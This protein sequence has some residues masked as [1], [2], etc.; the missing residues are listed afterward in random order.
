MVHWCSQ[1]KLV[2]LAYLFFI[3]SI[4]SCDTAGDTDSIPIQSVTTFESSMPISP[5][6]C[7]LPMS[8][9]PKDLQSERFE[10]LN[11][12]ADDSVNG[13]S[14]WSGGSSWRNK[15]ANTMN[16]CRSP[17]PGPQT[18]HLYW[19]TVFANNIAVNVWPIVTDTGQVIV[20][21]ERNIVFC[22]NADGSLV[23]EHFSDNEIIDIQVGP[24]S[25]VFIV[26]DNTFTVLNDIGL[27]LWEMN[28][29]N[30]NENYGLRNSI[31]QGLI[32]L[33]GPVIAL[34]YRKPAGC[35][36]SVYGIH[37]FTLDGDFL[38]SLGTTHIANPAFHSDNYIVYSSFGHLLAMTPEGINVWG[39]NDHIYETPLTQSTGTTYTS[40]NIGSWGAPVHVIEATDGGGNPLFY[41]MGFT[42]IKQQASGKYGHLYFTGIASDDDNAYLFSM[43]PTGGIRWRTALGGTDEL[44]TSIAV[45][46]DEN[47]FV[48]GLRGVQAFNGDGHLIWSYSLDSNAASRS[49]LSMDGT[50][51]VSNRNQLLAFRDKESR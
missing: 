45:D 13:N 17:Y 11:E 27:T 14:S 10:L 49:C 15:F 34:Y 20:A 22:I 1:H 32:I 26:E 4:V 19:R 9:Q 28:T 41:Q 44:S 25:R 21:T 50:L 3:L 7:P 6:D 35:S 48:S 43:N 8:A 51:Y 23:W 40:C 31:L 5:S 18:G 38:Y 39:R 16:H 33:P 30:N 47:I 24:D 12:L 29:N 36:W 37:F 46:G 42:S 2:F